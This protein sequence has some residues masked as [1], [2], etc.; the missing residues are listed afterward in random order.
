MTTICT[1]IS[2]MTLY[3][4]LHFDNR[5]ADNHKLY[6]NYGGLNVLVVIYA[7]VVNNMWFYICRI[8]KERDRNN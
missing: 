8:S 4:E 3:L 2:T 7:D 1:I 6:F 5:N